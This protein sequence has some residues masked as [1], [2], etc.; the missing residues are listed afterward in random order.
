MSSF[1]IPPIQP[2]SLQ[3]PSAV[4]LS[5]VQH[6]QS[7]HDENL[8]AAQNSTGAQ[9]AAPA[10]ASNSTGTSVTDD[11]A[12][13]QSSPDP[14]ADVATG[15]DAPVLTQTDS[16][17]SAAND[18]TDGGSLAD[19]T[20]NGASSEPDLTQALGATATYQG[21]SITA[22]TT[23]T[24]SSTL[25]LGSSATPEA[26]AQGLIQQQIERNS[27]ALIGGGA[28]LGINSR[29]TDASGSSQNTVIRILNAAYGTGESSSSAAQPVAASATSP[30]DTSLTAGPA[31]AS[32][33]PYDTLVSA[34]DA[35]LA[36]APSAIGPTLKNLVTTGNF[37]NKTV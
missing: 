6:Q 23:P 34:I 31:T 12:T 32:A 15:S 29:S 33:T 16:S 10:A 19:G 20:D 21:V 14:T 30:T 11:S 24:N 37:I 1:A 17:L 35:N 36:I 2:L 27:S 5:I 3:S 22:A 8:N 25:A 28:T 26:I 4:N 13:L 7:V 9:S 18:N